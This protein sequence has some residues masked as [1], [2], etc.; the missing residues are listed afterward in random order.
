MRAGRFV[1]AACAHGDGLHDD[2]LESSGPCGGRPAQYR[3]EN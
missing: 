1:R 3:G 2:G